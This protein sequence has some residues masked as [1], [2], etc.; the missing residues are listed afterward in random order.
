MDGLHPLPDIA[1][2][3]MMMHITSTTL[4]SELHLILHL[5]GHFEE[6]F[7]HVNGQSSTICDGFNEIAQF[8]Y[9]Q[10][11]HCYPIHATP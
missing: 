4:K 5:M 1:S 8:L 9:Q 6:A 10:Q 3:S 2:Q 11:M 7:V